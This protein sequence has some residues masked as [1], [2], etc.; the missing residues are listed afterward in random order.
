MILI[1]SQGQLGNQL[2]LLA[3]VLRERRPREIVVFVGFTDLARVVSLRKLGFYLPLGH[4]FDRKVKRVFKKLFSFHPR[5]CECVIRHESG[6]AMVQRRRSCH[7]PLI[8][9]FGL[10]QSE[11]I[12]PLEPVGT[13]VSHEATARKR[14]SAAR[15][16]L[17][18]VG[19]DPERFA[20]LHIRLGDYAHF[21]VFGSTPVLPASWYINVV[22]RLREAEPDIPIVVFSDQ[23][24]AARELFADSEGFFYFPF[25]DVESFFA[26][27]MASHGVLSAS[28]FSWWAAR[29]ARMGHPEGIFVAPMYWMGFKAERWFPTAEIQ[30]SFLEYIAVD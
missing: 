10:C 7:W 23:I 24:D 14:S 20:F 28:T 30:A 8:F 13:L 11:K 9:E 2:F 21:N 15:S 6:H 22:A 3:A 26:M 18:S 5:S 17:V 29:I 1:R 12:A 27:S 25:D 4:Y 19:V 16:C